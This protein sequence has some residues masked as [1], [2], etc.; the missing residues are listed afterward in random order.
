VPTM[1][2]AVTDDT[3]DRTVK[4]ANVSSALPF[5]QSPAPSY[6]PVAAFS[7]PLRPPRIAAPHCAVHAR[8]CVRCIDADR[9]RPRGSSPRSRGSA[10][11]LSAPCRPS[12]PTFSRVQR[13]GRPSED[14]DDDDESDEDDDYDEEEPSGS[15]GLPFPLSSALSLV[16]SLAPPTALSPTACRTPVLVPLQS[17]PC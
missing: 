7:G 9:T 12:P 15:A 4:L 2:D 10:P 3:Y 14:D 17:L 6:L 8:T 5:H 16:P 13:L 11:P 1:S